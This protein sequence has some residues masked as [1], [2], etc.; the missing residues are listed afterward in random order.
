MHT[1]TANSNLEPSRERQCCIYL[2]HD[3]SRVQQLST[4]YM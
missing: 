3:T 1:M 2:H 4:E